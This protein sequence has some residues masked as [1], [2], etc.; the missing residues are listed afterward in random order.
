[1]YSGSSILRKLLSPNKLPPSQIAAIPTEKTLHPI[2]GIKA[3]SYQ[4]LFDLKNRRQLLQ[5]NVLSSGHQ[6]N[7]QSMIVEVDL[8]SNTLILDTL[9]PITPYAPIKVG[10]HLSVSHHSNGELLCFSGRLKAISHDRDAL[11]AMELPEEIGYTSRRFYPR[12]N[13]GAKHSLLLRLNSPLGI[14]WS[15]RVINV[16]AGGARIS[17]GGN[18]SNQLR[19]DTHFTKLMLR[20]NN[21]LTIECAAQLKSYKYN[22]RPYEHTELSLA[23]RNMNFQQR[24]QLQNYICFQIENDAVPN[25]ALAAL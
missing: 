21:E 11:Y 20:I 3:E 16:S 9:T 1:M 12:W 2:N 10:D 6:E 7:Y 5:V 17:V 23:F 15:A 22:R 19:R 4:A 13:P 14:P 18:L 25:P 24:L 8:I